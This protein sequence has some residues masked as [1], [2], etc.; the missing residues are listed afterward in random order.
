MS[1]G[2]KG[3]GENPS[4]VMQGDFM[5]GEVQGGEIIWKMFFIIYYLK[6]LISKQLTKEKCLK[7]GNEVLHNA[8]FHPKTVAY[9]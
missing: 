2:D 4:P 6:N 3:T 5:H 8:E 9:L 1:L 7:N